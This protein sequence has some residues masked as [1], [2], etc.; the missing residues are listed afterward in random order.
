MA[1]EIRLEPGWLEQLR[2]EFEKD[3]MKQLKDF[4]YS[5]KQQ[6]KVIYPPSNRWFHAFNQTPFEQV[7]VVI[8]GQDPYHGP[9]QANGLCFSVSSKVA[10]PPSLQNIFTELS[11]DMHMDTSDSDNDLS[12]WAQQ[13]VLLINSVLTVEQGQ[14]GSHAGQGWEQFTDEALRKLLNPTR[15]LGQSNERDQPKVFMLWGNYAKRKA[16]LIQQTRQ[17]SS[18]RHCVIESAHPSPLSVHRG[19]FGSRPFSRANDFLMETGQ[20]PIEW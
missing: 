17:R 3:Y 12:R 1:A 6:G 4:L 13:G 9:N 2:A 7:K 20:D 18:L 19:F 15:P 5:R 14:A 10:R 11:T 16:A 8:I